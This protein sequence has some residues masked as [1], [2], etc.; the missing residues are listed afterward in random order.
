MREAA[1]VQRKLCFLHINAYGWNPLRLEDVVV[2]RHCGTVIEWVLREAS[3]LLCICVECVHRS[4]LFYNSLAC[5]LLRIRP[6]VLLRACRKSSIRCDIHDVDIVASEYRILY[7][8]LSASTDYV[9]TLY[10]CSVYTVYVFSCAKVYINL[11]VGL[12]RSLYEVI[13]GIV[14]SPYVHICVTG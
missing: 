4:S 13:Q 3:Y 14:Y 1:Y 12:R 11:L 7:A 6:I 2:H 10:I 8:Y 5:L 9:Q